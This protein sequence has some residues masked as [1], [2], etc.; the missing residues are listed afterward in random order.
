M[1][2]TQT[3]PASRALDAHESETLA[4]RLEGIRRR[5][6]QAAERSA[7]PVTAITLI[8]VSKTMPVEQVR[9]A[10]AAGLRTFGENRIQEAQSKIAAMSKTE[11][12]DLRW[13]LVG[14]LQT[15]KAP[16]AAGLFARVQSVDSVRLAQRLDA[17]AA[18]LG[19]ILPILLE[20]NVGG[21]ASK[22][23]F[24]PAETLEA[25]QAI[26]RLSHLRPQGLMTVAPLTP[27]P[28]TVRP[29]FRDLRMLRDLLRREAPTAEDDG[30]WAELSMG[31][32]DDFEVAIEEGATLIRIGRGLFGKRLAQPASMTPARLADGAEGS[33]E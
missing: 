26:A 23:G 31:M 18:A 19:R 24:A 1:D 13:E 17:Q 9:A 16:Q 29:V 8:A 25:A 12:P 20:V 27:D 7:R 14:H 15:N 4:S 5:V 2:V 22:L 11:A 6:A 32:T 33:N 30:G 21:E 3:Q 28:E 10:Y